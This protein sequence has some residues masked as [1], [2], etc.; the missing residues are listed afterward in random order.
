MNEHSLIN[1]ISTAFGQQ[2]ITEQSP[3][4]E[5]TN[6]LQKGNELV[7]T[8]KDTLTEKIEPHTQKAAELDTQLAPL[9]DKGMEPSSNAQKMYEAYLS[10]VTAYQAEVLFV[11]HNSNEEKVE[12]CQRALG[13]S[14][15]H[16][17]ATTEELLAYYEKDWQRKLE[18]VVTYEDAGFTP[19]SQ[20]QASFADL[21]EEKDSEEAIISGLKYELN[22]LESLSEDQVKEIAKIDEKSDQL[23]EALKVL[24]TEMGP[25]LAALSEFEDADHSQ[26]LELLQ[27]SAQTQHGVLGAYTDKTGIY[28]VDVV[29]LAKQIIYQA[30]EKAK[31]QKNHLDIYLTAKNPM[32]I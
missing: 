3:S 17:G 13:V 27:Q 12:A 32:R 20:E 14:G 4:A 8:Q 18:A 29:N 25:K 16:R 6:Y 30:A 21:S 1:K 7:A 28:P 26:V 23:I 15:I 11:Q 22:E 5:T 2:K 31:G 10:L 19:R 9:K 24:T